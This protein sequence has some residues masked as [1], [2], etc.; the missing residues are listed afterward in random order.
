MA[1]AELS[2]TTQE[3]IRIAIECPNEWNIVVLAN[4]FG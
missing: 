1:A 2:E 4:Q 3:L